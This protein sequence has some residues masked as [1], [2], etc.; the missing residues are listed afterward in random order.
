MPAE[1]GELLAER[2]ACVRRGLRPQLLALGTWHSEGV[3]SFCT[4]CPEP[5]RITQEPSFPFAFPFQLD[6]RHWL[7]T[8]A[9]TAVCVELR[10]FAPPLNVNIFIPAKIK[11]S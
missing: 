10:F 3:P 11:C 1:L 7:G 9:A 2:R 4:T 6:G 8:D 5:F